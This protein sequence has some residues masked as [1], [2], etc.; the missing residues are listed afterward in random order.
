MQI[1]K[2]IPNNP[3]PIEKVQFD[4]IELH[5]LRLDQIH[6][7]VSGNKFF[8]LKYNLGEALKK[9]E[10]QILTFGGAFSNHIA[11]TAFAASQVNLRSIG[12]IRGEKVDNPTLA[13]AQ[14]NGMELHFISRTDYR[15]KDQPEMRSKLSVQFGD[16]HLIPEGGTNQLA[17]QGTAEI[18]K[19]IPKH[20]ERIATSLGTA[21]TMAGLIE[22]SSV[23]Q[24]II[25]FPP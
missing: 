12:V 21:G 18:H 3:T 20:Y 1:E 5:V 7:F 17:I 16:F 6:P 15:S 13:F 8:K 23:T 24:K 10:N 4:G 25:G 2:I 19:L 11:A 14:E 9:G 22:G